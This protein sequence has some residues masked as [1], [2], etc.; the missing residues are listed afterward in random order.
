MH[1][2]KIIPKLFMYLFAYLFMWM[3]S[4]HNNLNLHSYFSRVAGCPCSIQI[5]LVFSLQ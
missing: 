2:G 1:P 5:L 3:T 4:F